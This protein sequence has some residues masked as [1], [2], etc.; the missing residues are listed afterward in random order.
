MRTDLGTPHLLS[1]HIPGSMCVLLLAQYLESVAAIPKKEALA[2]CVQRHLLTSG[3]VKELLQQ[4]NSTP[5]RLVIWAMQTIEATNIDPFKQRHLIELVTNLR[6]ALDSLWSYDDTPIPFVYYHLMNLLTFVVLILKG[7]QDGA[8]ESRYFCSEEAGTDDSDA[9]TCTLNAGWII[10]LVFFH[11]LFNGI[12]IAL[13]E[14]PI[15][16]T[17]PFVDDN[18]AIAM[19]RYMD[20][21]LEMHSKLT[22]YHNSRPESSDPGFATAHT[23]IKP[24]SKR[25]EVDLR[26]RERRLRTRW[27]PVFN[28]VHLDERKKAAAVIVNRCGE[29]NIDQVLKTAPPVESFMVNRTSSQPNAFA[30]LAAATRLG[31]GAR[32]R[33]SV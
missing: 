25:V 26:R 14:L 30:S 1:A 11:F 28:Q 31:V 15:M 8:K 32:R 20:L 7:L 6:K 2:V 13:K 21:S 12:I 17:D 24:L 5:R 19:E 23:T 4:D 10:C 27:R 22:N 18:N 29:L 16:L 9:A 3:E 33:G